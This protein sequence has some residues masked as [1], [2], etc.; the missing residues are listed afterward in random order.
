MLDIVFN[1][2]A[3]RWD[4]VSLGAISCASAPSARWA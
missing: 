1:P 2:N 3:T 4:A